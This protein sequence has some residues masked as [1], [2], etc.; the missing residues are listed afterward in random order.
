MPLEPSFGNIDDLNPDWPLGTDPLAEGDD[1]IR[2]I[3]LSLQGNVT[4]DAAQTRLLADAIATVFARAGSVEVIAQAAASA[5]LALRDDTDA[6]NYAVI[7]AAAVGG[8]FVDSQVDAQPVVLR[9][10]G[11]ASDEQEILRGTP[12][13]GTTIFF[14]GLPI[15]ATVATGVDVLANQIDLNNSAVD[16]QTNIIARNSLGG[17]NLLVKTTSGDGAIWQTDPSGAIQDQWILMQR[18]GSVALYFDSVVKLATLVNGI[19]INGQTNWTTGSGSPEG[20]VVAN[21]GS[22]YSDQVSGSGFPL[23][24]KNFSNGNT[25]WLKVDSSPP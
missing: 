9:G 19:Q 7:F 5:R 13:T 22:L 10:R 18:D 24:I 20:V 3:K 16:S 15:F 12:D 23:W 8:L 17:L 21:P 1:H 14:A 2:G 4:G 25:G 11:A 6:L